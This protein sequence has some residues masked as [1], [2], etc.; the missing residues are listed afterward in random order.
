MQCYKGGVEMPCDNFGATTT[1]YDVPNVNDCCCYHNPGAWTYFR[2]TT[3]NC[4]YHGD[5]CYGDS[6]CEDGTFCPTSRPLDPDYYNNTTRYTITTYISKKNVRHHTPVHHDSSSDD[7]WTAQCVPPAFSAVGIPLLLTSGL[8]LLALCSCWVRKRGQRRRAR[9]LEANFDPRRHNAAT[10]E[11]R[12]IATYPQASAPPPQFARPGKPYESV[13]RPSAPISPEASKREAETPPEAAMSGLDAAI[14][15]RHRQQR[16]RETEAAEA[17]PNNP[18]MY[19]MEGAAQP[20]KPKAEIGLQATESQVSPPIAAVVDASTSFVPR[21]AAGVTTVE[22][23]VVNSEDTGGLAAELA[24][25][26][27]LHSSGDLTDIEFRDAKAAAIS[28]A[29]AAA[30]A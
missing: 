28:K 20:G 30:D 4:N 26:S 25:L 1:S 14:A 8:L 21:S 5:T 3:A 11:S 17:Q 22:A 18:Y 6:N 19:E 24:T 29:A 27:A 15:A 13:P 10:A 9:G 2:T 23:I 7:T 12:P 16:S